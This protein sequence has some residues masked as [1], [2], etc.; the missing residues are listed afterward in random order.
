MNAVGSFVSLRRAAVARVFAPVAP[1]ARYRRGAAL[2]AAV[3]ALTVGPALALAD[4]VP[5]TSPSD[6]DG[7]VAHHYFPLQNSVTGL[8]LTDLGFVHTE[9][10]NR[11]SNQLWFYATS[12][13]YLVNLHT[14]QCLE[15]D[16]YDNGYGNLHTAVCNGTRSQMWGGGP[17]GPG[18][19]SLYNAQTRLCLES[20]VNVSSDTYG[21]VSGNAYAQACAPGNWQS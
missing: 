9:V 1:G 13:D 8:C 16:G 15:N 20:D 21:P 10:C 6:G 3:C 17:G 19:Y 18:G 7:S 4:P 2:L 14:N 5:G 12:A 11:S